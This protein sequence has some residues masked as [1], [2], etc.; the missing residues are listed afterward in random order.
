MSY[1]FIIFSHTFSVSLFSIRKTKNK[2]HFSIFMLSIKFFFFG[3]GGGLFK[4]GFL[5]TFLTI[6]VGA[7]LRWCMLKFGHLM[8]KCGNHK[9]IV[10]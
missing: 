2:V 5:L 6:R 4:D 9:N 10:G 1:I 7:Y 3:G 8:N